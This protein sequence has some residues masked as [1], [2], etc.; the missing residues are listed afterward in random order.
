MNPVTD[1][2]EQTEQLNLPVSSREVLSGLPDGKVQQLEIQHGNG[3]LIRILTALG[4]GGPFRSTSPWELQDEQGRHLIHAGGYAALPFGEAYPKLVAFVRE[5]LENGATLGFAQQS[6]SAW[7]AAL[8][9]NLVALVSHFAPSHTDSQVFF[10]NSGAGAIEAALKFVR[11]A[12]PGSPVILNFG[13]AYHGKTFGALS[14]TP[15]EEYQ[16][17][18]RPFHGD[19]RTVPFGDLLALEQEIRSIGPEK[20]AAIFIE[21]IQGEA[22][23]RLPPPEFLPGVYELA[24]KHDILLI[25]D[26]IQT[27]LGRSG[28]WFASIAGGLEPDII[29]L[30][31]PLSG[32]LVPIGATIARKELVTKLLGG[33]SSKRHSSTFG[34]G[35]L[36]TAVAL[37]SLEIIQEEGLVERSRRLGRKGLHRLRKAQARHPRLL[38]DVR[39]SG[40]L[41]AL[42]LQGIVPPKAMNIQQETLATMGSA[43]ALRTLHKQGVHGCYS[44]NSAGVVRLTPALN[45]PE[46]L[47]DELFDRIDRFAQQNPQPWR[48]L[49][50]LPTTRLPKLLRTLRS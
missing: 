13:G 20:I 37:R 46:P 10:S 31:K 24:Q 25:A 38:K 33:M 19:V 26:E 4:I 47:F 8:E 50:S 29:T 36:A 3:D 9:A 23:V 39:A 27:G 48:M 22:G 6:A 32:G 44:L 35:S 11:A 18:F 49:T 28:H 42:E 16:G 2:Q 41:F 14:L 15:N 21:P 43:L 5:Y 30:A 34:G 45:I 7:R 12:R 1:S 17:P 40:M